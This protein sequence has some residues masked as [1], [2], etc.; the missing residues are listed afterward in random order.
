LAPEQI[1]NLVETIHKRNNG[2]SKQATGAAANNL[3]LYQVNCTFLDA[4]GGSET[5]YLIARAIQFFAPGIPQ[6]YYIGLMGG[7]NDMA[8]LEKSKVGRDINRHYYTPQ[9]IPQA[10]QSSLVQ[11]QIELIKM[12]NAHPA[13]N[14]K[15]A[16]STPT[17]QKL[18]IAWTLDAQWI[19]LVVDFAGP[20][21]VITGTS[22]TGIFQ[23]NI[24]D[25]KN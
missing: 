11:K 13:F 24:R 7:R 12:R 6:V 15:V 9:E 18:E 20:G 22:P 17:H 1:D 10:I 23:K 19:K 14:G 3:D 16:I 5:E 4:L 2:Q 21:A 25:A 8:L